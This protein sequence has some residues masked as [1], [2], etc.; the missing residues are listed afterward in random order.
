MSL[1]NVPESTNY[2]KVIQCSWQ[3]QY[4]Q[5]MGQSMSFLPIVNDFLISALDF[6]ICEFRAI[7]VQISLKSVFFLF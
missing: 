3:F 5:H 6:G 4:V 2:V 7:N 1:C